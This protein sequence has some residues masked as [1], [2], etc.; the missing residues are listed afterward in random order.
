MRAPCLL[1]PPF[2]LNNIVDNLSTL[3]TF[4]LI[5]VELI[6][7]IF[8]VFGN[9]F[10]RKLNYPCPR[11]PFK[12]TLPNRPSF[13]WL[14]VWLLSVSLTPSCAPWSRSD[15]ILLSKA[16]WTTGP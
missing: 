4:V 8:R 15:I 10:W 1:T 3:L 7:W 13:L 14:T 11:Q 12:H 5:I 6:L 16:S 2:Y 9:R